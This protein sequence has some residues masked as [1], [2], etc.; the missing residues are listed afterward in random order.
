ME[1]LILKYKTLVEQNIST[2]SLES[3]SIGFSVRMDIE[4]KCYRM[5]I[6][7]L[8]SIIKSQEPIL[9]G[10]SEKQYKELMKCI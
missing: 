3:T 9:K 4:N 8:E 6:S 5:I 1:E 10:V 7:D 2:M